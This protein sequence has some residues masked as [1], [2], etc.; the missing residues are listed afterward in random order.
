MNN[1]EKSEYELLYELNELKKENEYLKLT[2]EKDI[3]DL[4]KSEDTLR[5][6]EGK[7]RQFVETAIEG[8]LSLDTD[9]RLTFV[10]RQMA[11]MLGYSAEE[12]LDKKYESFMPEDQL[13]EDKLQSQIRA[14]GKNAIYERCFLRKDGQRHWT[15]VSAKSIT[16][17][18]GKFAGSFG[19]F[20]DINERKLAEEA[21][22][23][24][25]E[26]YRR[27]VE[28]ANEGILQLDS[29]RRLTF[30]NQ[31]LATMLGYTIEEMLGRKYESFLPEDQLTEDKSQSKIRA[32]GKN[33]VYE[34]CFLRKDGQ[35]YW[36]LVSAKAITDSGGKFAGSFGMF[37]DINARRQMEAALQES[38]ERYRRI[39]ET[40]IEGILSLDSERR[41]NFVNQQLATMLGYTIE[42]ML[43]KK[44]ESFLPEDQLMEDKAQAKIRAQ[45]KNA[46]Y[47]R[48]FLRKDGQR[49]WMLVS[50][51]AITNSEGKI[52]GSFGMFT[53]INDRKKTEAAL[54]ES[55][56]RYRRIVETAIEGILQVDSDR[57]LIFV[58][59][60]LAT[61]LGYTVEEML[62]RKYESFLPEDQL[63][64]DKVQSK[65]RAQ[66][67][68]AVY[69]RCFLRKDGQRHWMLVSAKAITDSDGKFAG[70]FGMF[71]DINKRKHMEAALQESEEK[72]RRIVETANEGILSFGSDTRI[73]FIN[74]Q[75]ATMLGY[76]VEEMLG[77]K[78]ETFLAED[79][80]S[81]HYVQMKNRALGK[82]TV[83]ERCF[84]RKDGQRYWMLVSAKTILDTAGNFAGSFAM[85]TDINERKRAE[86][87]LYESELQYR[88]LFET[89]REGIV[90]I[91]KSKL[92][93]FN[94]MM[95]EIT[96]Y[97]Y[98]EL[99]NM[100]FFEFV[101]QK[102]RDLILANHNKTITGGNAEQ[103]YQFRMLKK[104]N[105]LCWVEMG[106][107]KFTWKGEAATLNFI[108]DITE[109]K[110]TEIELVKLN[111]ELKLS[112]DVIEENLSQ[113][114]MLVEKLEKLNSEKDKFFSII[115]HDLRSPFQGFIGL[116]E[117]MV[118]EINI[119]SK[120]E[121]TNIS[122]D[123]NK[124][125]NSLY[126]LLQN[127]LEWSQMQKGTINF[128][129]QEWQLS[130]IVGQSYENM[131]QRASQKG[132]T[133]E[134]NIS[135]SIRVNADEKMLNT[136]VR[137]LLSNAVKFTTTEG[138]VTISAKETNDNM[139][140]VSVTDTGIGMSENDVNKLFKLDEKVRKPGTDGEPSTGLGLLLCKEFVENHGGKIWIKSQENIGST[141]YFTVP[142][143]EK[144]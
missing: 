112:K 120:T 104:D 93:Y 98:E 84:K 18:E 109:Q 119:L 17:S 107:V 5:K 6:S 21:L 20:T 116:T 15:L 45:G 79:Q 72:Y 106:S 9:R 34:R 4:K 131:A 76:T 39:V 129:P 14:K 73:N 115:A 58:N 25:E 41:L 101:Y 28:T 126:K 69:E 90:V 56:E 40:A 61:M 139:V 78:I 99:L 114:N 86:A 64:D 130:E 32:Q 122:N 143:V 144:K 57:C 33:A 11:A 82:D 63:T 55:E 123:L 138:K 97:S 141:F 38:E 7:Y 30:V 88:L 127:L 1:I 133:L 121:L 37:T 142:S 89:A 85:F 22:Q 103:R 75:M 36:M 81:E 136:V 92:S 66:G 124:S 13:N 62:G 67:K 50:A 71:T 52:A 26:R 102:D 35:R 111:E 95:L 134:N 137:N 68:N 24:S 29:D 8:I 135:D 60:Q 91:Q 43:G 77:Q 12:M 128:A 108:I 140:E 46:F 53:D 59:Q 118:E 80:L 70:S 51:K 48:C 74:R 132:I 49:Y 27:I 65:I 105:S 16:D 110:L 117:I 42:E 125:A 96:G 113:K 23:E 54:Q 100:N 19:I 83:Y 44:Y 2:Y 87:A 10:N 47:E 94:P 3:A 31:Q